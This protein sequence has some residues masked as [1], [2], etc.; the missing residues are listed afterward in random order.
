MMHR[1]ASLA[2]MLLLAGNSA[3]LPSLPAPLS[4]SEASLT[5]SFSGLRSDKGFIRACLTREPRFFP[6]CEKDPHA[7]KDSVAAGP[8]AR[9]SFTGIASG[10]YALAV[11]HDENGNSRAD[12]LMGIPREGVGFSENPRLRFSAPKF[13]AARFR[14]GSRDLTMDVRLQYFL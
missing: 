1:I 13:D 4:P 5:V 2:A 10:D 6:S 8:H 14:V 3:L 11:L 9:L 12:M 7:L